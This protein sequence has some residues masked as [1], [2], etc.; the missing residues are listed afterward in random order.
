MLEMLRRPA[1]FVPLLISAGFLIAMLAR[2]AEGTLVRQPDEDAMAHL[3]QLLMPLQAV[4]IV[5]FAAF[6]LPK[7]PRSTMKVL[8]LQAVA[9]LAVLAVVRLK[10]L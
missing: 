1:A 7:R 3:F 6:W 10:N 5:A 9:L 4:I 8:C 2:F